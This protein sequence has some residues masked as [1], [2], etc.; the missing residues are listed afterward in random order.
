[1]K[2]S[3]CGKAI[4]S[5]YSAPTEDGG[6]GHY[7]SQA[8]VAEATKKWVVFSCHVCF[9]NPE[10]GSSSLHH[11]AAVSEL[12]RLL[13]PY[14][15][16]ERLVIYLDRDL[17]EAGSVWV[18]VTG[19]RAWV[20][21]ITLPG[22]VDSY[23]RCKENG[24]DEKIGMMLSNGQEDMFHWSWTVPR[25]D[26]IRA[27]EYFL[28]HAERDPSLCWVSEPNRPFDEPAVF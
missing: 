27:L 13:Q 24:P 15:N 20:T 7:C 3:G 21:H 22:G 18:H 12:R 10:P 26:G 1:M 23:C 28:E 4:K 11:V 9:F 14:E 5:F 25:S 17:G 8:C 16:H 2:C 19:D 6:A